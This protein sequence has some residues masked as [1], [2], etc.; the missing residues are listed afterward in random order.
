VR[1]QHVDFSCNDWSGPGSLVARGFGTT[2]GLVTGGLVGV[3]VIAVRIVTAG[4][5]A[6]DGVAVSVLAI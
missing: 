6:L 4:P 1:N 2:L 5:V 3:V